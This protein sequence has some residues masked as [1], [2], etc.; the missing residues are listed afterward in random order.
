[1][2][3]VL[4]TSENSNLTAHGAVRLLALSEL[5]R[6]LYIPISS[7]YIS[8]YGRYGKYGDYGMYGGYEDFPDRRISSDQI[9]LAKRG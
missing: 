7:L 6:F 9:Q 5:I 4:L 8:N 3:A 2:L 1:M